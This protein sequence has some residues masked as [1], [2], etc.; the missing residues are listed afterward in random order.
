MIARQRL[1][2]GARTS[3]GFDSDA[4]GHLPRMALARKKTQPKPKKFTTVVRD[5]VSGR[6]LPKSAAKRR[7]KTTIT[8]RVR[9]GR[10]GQKK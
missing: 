7:P 3:V 8:Q 10:R 1:R 4:L 5:A 6:F 2:R 9:L